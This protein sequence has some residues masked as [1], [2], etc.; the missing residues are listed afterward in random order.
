MMKNYT[1]EEALLCSKAYFKGDELSASVWVNKYA[2][3]DSAGYIYENSPEQMHQRL[4]GEFAR[5]EKKY[6][7]PMTKEEIFD[8]LK[9]F[10][11][12]IPQG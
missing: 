2:L 4:A 10:K 8:L 9:D 12:V 11:Y 3:K 5:I 6:K 1:F 7:N